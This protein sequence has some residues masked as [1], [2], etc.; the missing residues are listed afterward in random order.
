MFARTRNNKTDGERRR[1]YS[2]TSHKN[3]TVSCII[4]VQDNKRNIVFGVSPTS[5]RTDELFVY[6][7]NRTIVSLL[8]ENKTDTQLLWW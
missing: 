5:E 7:K 6:I 8:Y 2:K 4:F 1:I 3:S